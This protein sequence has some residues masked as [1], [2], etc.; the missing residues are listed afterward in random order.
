MQADLPVTAEPREQDAEAAA[1][2]MRNA[3]AISQPQKPRVEIPGLGCSKCRWTACSKCRSAQ[4]EALQVTLAEHC[5][6]FGDAAE[7]WSLSV[8]QGAGLLVFG[9]LADLKLSTCCTGCQLPQVMNKLQLSLACSKSY[10]MVTTK[11]Q[12]CVCCFCYI[13][14]NALRPQGICTHHEWDDTSVVRSLY[15]GQAVKQ[16]VLLGILATEGK[17][18]QGHEHSSPQSTCAC[19]SWVP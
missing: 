13:Y 9:R 2:G 6:A 1:Q 3:R 12:S 8:W 16:G 4:A 15:A 5:Q 14:S 17:S 19:L 10:Q 18:L 7:A 11:L